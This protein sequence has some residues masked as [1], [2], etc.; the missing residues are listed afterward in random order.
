MKDIWYKSLLVQIWHIPR[1]ILI[2]CIEIYQRTLSPDH[3]I[4]KR[5]FPYGYCKF[6]PTCSQYTKERLKADGTIVGFF[7]GVW[8]ILRCNP[9][10]EG[11][12]MK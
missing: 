12:R 6:E 8:Q 2:V 3:G 5:F 10:N 4:P 1:N 11:N 9:W 7:K